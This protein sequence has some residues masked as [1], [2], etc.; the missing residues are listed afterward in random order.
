MAY[1][2]E[3]GPTAFERHRKKVAY[4]ILIAG[5]AWVVLGVLR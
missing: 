3:R 1:D 2:W 4:A 5:I